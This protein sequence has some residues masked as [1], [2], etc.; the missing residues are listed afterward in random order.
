MS[1]LRKVL[2][3]QHREDEEI[4]R[5]RAEE[6]RELDEEEEEVVLV[7]GMLNQSRQHHC[8]CSLNVDRHRHSRGKNILEDY[9]I[10]NSLYPVSYFRERYRMQPHLFQEIM[11]DVCNYDTYFVQKYDALGVL[12]FLS[13]QKLTAALRMLAYEAS[14]DQ[15]DEIA[16][17]GKSTILECL[18]RFCD[19]I[20]TLYTRDYL[21]K[22]TPRDLRRL[23]RKSEA[24]GFPNMI[25][26]IDCMY[27]LRKNFPTPWQGNYGNKKGQKNIILE[28]VA[29]F[30]I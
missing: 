5:K 11:H 15:V 4:R 30:D 27:W 16:K 10:P 28:A 8:G 29:S 21:L 3:R 1:N 25:G 19:T 22:P 13:E 24:Q 14:A 20:E 6:D 7:V 12:G 17:I 23:L 2:E 18:V 26:G 9:F